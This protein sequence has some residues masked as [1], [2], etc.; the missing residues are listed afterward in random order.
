MISV[1]ACRSSQPDTAVQP[2]EEPNS[3]TT[4]WGRIYQAN[5][6]RLPSHREHLAEG[7]GSAARADGP[8]GSSRAAPYPTSVPGDA[9]AA[10]VVT[11]N[12]REVRLLLVD[13]LVPTVLAPLG[14]R[15][16]GA[17]EPPLHR[18]LPHRRFAASRSRDAEERR[19]VCGKPA[20]SVAS[21]PPILARPLVQCCRAEWPG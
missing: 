15:R 21:D 17:G 10:V 20:R 7:G 2:V 9:I 12:R 16:Q 4:R 11:Q 13:W 18:P 8:T 6:A 19:I 5:L 1:S 14:H 3:Y